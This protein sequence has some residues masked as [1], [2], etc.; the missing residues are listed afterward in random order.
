M[1]LFSMRMGFR[2]S[3]LTLAFGVV[4]G[5]LCV[6]PSMAARPVPQNGRKNAP[7]ARKVNP[8]EQKAY[9]A[10]H[11]SNPQDAD[12][13]I[14]LGESFIKKYPSGPYTGVVYSALVQAYYVKQDWKNFYAAADKAL[15]I[16]PNDVDVLTKV[17]WVIPH[18]YNANDA[19]AAQ[20]LS[21]AEEYAKRAIA[22]IPNLAKPKSLT[23]QQFEAAKAVDLAEAHSAL[24]LVYFR[25]KDYANSAKELT[26]AT[27]GTHPDPTDLYVLGLDLQTTQQFAQAADAFNRCAQ[28]PG[29]LQ[30]R[31]KQQ[32]NAAT[33]LP[34][35]AK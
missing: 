15:A 8:K 3:V 14:K 7:P 31:C 12:Q 24:G 4:L 34:G 6:A 30:A 13:R 16:N 23:D 22:E 25:R 26:L 35:A 17:S 2:A 33:S 9:K 19:N 29:A 21:K 1:N 10:F 27:Q 20:Q 11:D 32:A 18:I 5:M 28:I